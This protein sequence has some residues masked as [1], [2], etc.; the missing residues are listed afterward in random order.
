MSLASLAAQSNSGQYH[1]LDVMSGVEPS[2]IF[3]WSS[4]MAS[5]R[6]SLKPLASVAFNEQ[7]GCCIY[8]DKPM[9][10]NDPERFSR[11]YKLTPKQV[12][13][14]RCTGEH[15]YRHSSGGKASRENIVAAHWFC[16][17]RRH[18][19]GKDPAPDVFRGEVQRR[20]GKGKWFPFALSGVEHSQSPAG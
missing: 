9:W 15:L 14:L 7:A 18:Q 2:P 5:K 20:L 11:Q 13:L 1:R 4:P 6:S 10:L 19:G 17:H 12:Q 16:N 8:C 3:F